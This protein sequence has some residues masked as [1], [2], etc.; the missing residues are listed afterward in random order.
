MDNPGLHWLP[1]KKIYQTKPLAF[2]VAVLIG[3]I[4]PLLIGYMVV[5]EI[6]IVAFALLL[7]IPAF[8]IFSKN[9]FIVLFIWLAIGPFIIIIPSSMQP[10]YWLVHRLLPIG[11]LAVV[12]INHLTGLHPR[13]FPKLTMAELAMFLYCFASL[14]SVITTSN[15]PTDGITTLYDRII[16]PMSL[17]LLIRIWSP[18]E[19]EIKQLTPMLLFL[20]FSQI[21]IGLLAWFYPSA[22]PDYWLDWAGQRTTGSLRSY[23]AYVSAMLFAGLPLLHTALTTKEGFYKKIL[24][25]GFFLS[26]LGA[27]ISFSRAGWLALGVVLACLFYLY[28]KGMIRSTLVIIP[29]VAILAIGPLAEQIQWASQRLDSPESEASALSRLPTFLASVRM[30]QARPFFGWGYENFNEYDFQFYSRV[31]DLINPEKDHSSHNYFL[32]LLAE[33]GMVGF[34]LFL[35]PIAYWLYQTKKT[36]H[37]YPSQGF[38][39]Q[40]LIFTLWLFPLAFGILNLFQSMRVIYALGIFWINLGLI[41]SL[42]SS[43]PKQLPALEAN[44]PLSNISELRKLHE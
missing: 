34:I 28:P 27:F 25:V 31:G 29:I 40:K 1:F 33:Q 5:N 9:P 43:S 12:W 42:V 10:V 22:L 4:S 17:Y 15:D 39:S 14:V 41:A 20:V 44:R 26:L 7:A 18:Q 23:G 6:W 3:I 36:L 2:W 11:A 8:I 24:L 30:F 35:F 37:N 21:S 19:R 38:L 13:K 32:T 16:I